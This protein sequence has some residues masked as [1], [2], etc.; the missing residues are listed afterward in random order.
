MNKPPSKKSSA[1]KTILLAT[2]IFIIGWV[3][4]S[5]VQHN[6]DIINQKGEIARVQTS[7]SASCKSTLDQTVAD[8]RYTYTTG[9]N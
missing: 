1:I 8:V 3:F 6:G 4:G 7:D 5:M 2:G 9:L